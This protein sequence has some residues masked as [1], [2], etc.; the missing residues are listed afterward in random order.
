M[1]KLFKRKQPI[2]VMGS[3]RFVAA[4]SEY[5]F[6]EAN[7]G[8]DYPDYS[9]H[10]VGNLYW[11]VRVGDIDV[12]WGFGDESIGFRANG[13]VKISRRNVSAVTFDGRGFDYKRAG[14][15]NYLYESELGA[16]GFVGFVPYVQRTVIRC[17]K[18]IAS[19][20]GMEKF[21]K[22]L[23]YL[24]ESREMAALLDEHKLVLKTVTIDHIEN[25]N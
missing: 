25:F 17:L 13:T 3:K 22:E 23:S 24:G 7:N 8:A 5:P 20:S 4:Y 9:F 16:N 12:P 6:T 11:C 2:S 21:T 10:K 19:K 18:E 14:E 1:F 15:I